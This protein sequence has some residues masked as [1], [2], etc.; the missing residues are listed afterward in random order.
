MLLGKR[1]E[2]QGCHS[3]KQ[4]GCLTIASAQA[5][6]CRGQGAGGIGLQPR[7]GVG[8]KFDE[9]RPCESWV[10]FRP[11]LKRP[12]KVLSPVLDIVKPL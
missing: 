6:G 8:G 2:V 3:S 4:V 11:F 10:S 5:K 9:N 12:K 7:Q 1:G